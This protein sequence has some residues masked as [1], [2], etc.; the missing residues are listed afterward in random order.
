MKTMIYDTI[1][2][3]Y[4]ILNG[5][6]SGEYQTVSFNSAFDN[7]CIKNNKIFLRKFKNEIVPEDERTHPIFDAIRPVYL[8]KEQINFTGLMEIYSPHETWKLK[9]INGGLV[10]S[11]LI[12]V[13]DNDHNKDINNEDSHSSEEELEYWSGEGYVEEEDNDDYEG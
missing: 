8:G 1:E 10:K 9:F 2:I 13:Q 12:N 3:D 7:Y 5:P 11:M 6:S 4:D